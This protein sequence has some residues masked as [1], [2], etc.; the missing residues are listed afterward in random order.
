MNA[1]FSPNK[2]RRL[3]DNGTRADKDCCK[4]E[5]K[6]GKKNLTEVNQYEIEYT[7]RPGKA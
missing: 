3:L 4:R 2:P 5:K 6:K 1:L 7:L